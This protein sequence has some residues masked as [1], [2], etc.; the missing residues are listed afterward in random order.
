M[1]SINFYYKNKVDSE[2]LIAAIES[3]VLFTKH[4]GPD[5]T[6]FII[7]DNFALGFNLLDIVGGSQPLY[8]KENE[9]ILICNGEIFNHIELKKKY[10]SNEKFMTHSDVEVILHL[11][12]TFGLA[13][14]KY[15]EGQFSFLLFDLKANKILIARDR[16]GISPL[17]YYKQKRI[18]IVS[19][20]IK[21]IIA[22]KTIKKLKINKKAIAQNMFF[23]GTIPPSTCFENILQLPPACL[24]I[25]DIKTG[26]MDVKNYWNQA[27]RITQRNNLESGKE[28]ESLLTKS[29]KM[30]LQGKSKPGVYVSGGLDSSIIAYLTSKLSPDTKLFSI[31]FKNM[32]F[33]ESK[34]QNHLAKELGINLQQIFIG[35]SDIEDNLIDC[36]YHAETPLI[37]TAPIPMML[38]SRK[39]SE[40]GIKFVLCGEG[41]D[42]IFAG[43]P[44]FL[45]GKASFQDKWPT[46]KNYIKI[47]KDKNIREHLYFMYK[48]MSKT[49]KKE[50][51]T[52]NRKKEISTKLSQYLLSNQGDRMSMT[53]GVEQR[54]PYLDSKV[55]DFA[56]S[57]EN[58]FLIEKGEGKII[59]RQTFAN[60]LS[61]M[62]INR[63]KQG[64]L[65][66]DID[67]VKNML[68]KKK[69]I[70]LLNSES[71]NNTNIFDNYE[72]QKI[73][74]KVLVEKNLDNRT[75][76]LLI[77]VLTTQI[78]YKVFID[79]KSKLNRFAFRESK[80]YNYV[81]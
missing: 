79:R 59:L 70:N 7:K 60:K 58:K 40:Q 11:Y 68:K 65:T 57:L 56:F 54:F 38:L 42:E 45:N 13:C 78:L 24:G 39:V 30:R 21:S 76:S 62:L 75:A 37:R 14:V 50:S 12:K 3:M 63:K 8:D 33:D 34:Y 9:L 4:R 64:Y 47:F 81:L 25:Y 48:K 18:F 61:D 77:F 1:C 26:K 49:D 41:A 23:Y 20:E 67:V 32:D 36:I 31:A 72:I 10:F 6:K 69:Y 28:L 22:S 66:P 80:N 19:S 27:L 15:L 46:L 17:F 74:K 52:E 55:V 29:V 5:E 2:K 53:N 35:V 16:F 71:I 73:L 43:Y 44:V 51:I